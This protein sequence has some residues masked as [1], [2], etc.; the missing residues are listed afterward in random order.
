MS[1]YSLGWAVLPED[2]GKKS[3]DFFGTDVSLDNF[4]EC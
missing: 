1:T 4:A 2:F 3:V